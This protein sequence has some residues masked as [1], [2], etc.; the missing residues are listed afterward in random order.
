MNTITILDDAGMTG[1]G[2]ILD[3]LTD[4]TI[5]DLALIRIYDRKSLR[6]VDFL[7]TWGTSEKPPDFGIIW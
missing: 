7:D 5:V 6:I 2:I 1:Q 3:L 4:R